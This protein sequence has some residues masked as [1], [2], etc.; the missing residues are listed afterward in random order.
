MSVSRKPKEKDI[1]KFIQ[2]GG[3]EPTQN[4]KVI[5]DVKKAQSIKLRIPMDL[6]EQIDGLVASRKPS[7]S[8]HQWILEALYEKVERN[9]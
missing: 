3:S 2:G 9:S 7:P 5:S 8:R 4:N 6:L 1:E